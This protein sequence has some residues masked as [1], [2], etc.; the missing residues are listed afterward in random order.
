M[1]LRSH[2]FEDV[3]L[4]NENKTL[5]TEQGTDHVA[6][7]TSFLY[8]LI[9]MHSALYHNIY[10]T[11]GGFWS[12]NNISDIATSVYCVFLTLTLLRRRLRGETALCSSYR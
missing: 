12:H 10:S 7:N 8:Y 3:I 9:C 4:P 6:F 2:L 1:V 5:Q 11:L